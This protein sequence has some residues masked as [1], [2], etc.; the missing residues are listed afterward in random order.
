VSDQAFRD[1]RAG[2]LARFEV[3]QTSTLPFTKANREKAPYSCSN[4]KNSLY[5]L[6]T[7]YFITIDGFIVPIDFT[8]AI[9][10]NNRHNFGDV[11]IHV[12]RERFD[13][14]S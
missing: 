13:A 11:I 12:Q 10:D 1:L 9:T 7:C 8:Y 3:Y 6:F 14:G 5:S 2:R 4:S